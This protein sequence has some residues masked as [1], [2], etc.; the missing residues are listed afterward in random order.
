MQRGAPR[1]S[2]VQHSSPVK[3]LGKGHHQ[4]PHTG[5]Q[6][7]CDHPG[8]ARPGEVDKTRYEEMKLLSCITSE[9]RSHLFERLGV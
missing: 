1:P 4:Q 7:R 5:V 8:A 6:W 3:T 2:A 9:D